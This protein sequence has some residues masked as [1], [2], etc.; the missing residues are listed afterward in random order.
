MTSNNNKRKFKPGQLIIAHSHA[1]VDVK[2]RLIRRDKQDL[3]WF[4]VLVDKED[5]QSL[6]D[7]GVPWIEP[8]QTETFT[9]DY[10]ILKLVY[11]K[12]TTKTEVRTKDGKCIVR[13]HG[14]HRRKKK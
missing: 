14:K 8:E 5:A 11:K 13:K 1:G 3:G 2:I 7:A 4:G 12:R 6:K 9:F 10:Q